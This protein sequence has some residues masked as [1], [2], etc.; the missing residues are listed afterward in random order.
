INKLKDYFIEKIKHYYNGGTLTK[1]LSAPKESSSK[2]V[3]ASIPNG[4]VKNSKGVLTKRERGR[5]IVG[6]SPVRVRTGASTKHKVTGIL[7]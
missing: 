1:E 2:G 6:N 7:P 5:F 4:Y 3:P